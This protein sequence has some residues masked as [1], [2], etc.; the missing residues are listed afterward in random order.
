MY[1][2]TIQWFVDQRLYLEGHQ[3]FVDG[4]VLTNLITF[5]KK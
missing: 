3:V 5:V 1:P 4:K 2:M